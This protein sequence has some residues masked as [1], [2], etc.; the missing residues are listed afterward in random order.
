M[1]MVPIRNENCINFQD[2]NGAVDLYWAYTVQFFKVI[3]NATLLCIVSVAFSY[4]KQYFACMLKINC[5][6]NKAYENQVK[7]NK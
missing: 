3:V 5:K 7:N 1:F 6:G 4:L 2:S